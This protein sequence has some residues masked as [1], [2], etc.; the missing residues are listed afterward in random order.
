VYD[1]A[2]EDKICACRHELKCIGEDVSERLKIIPPQVTVIREIRKKYVCEHCEGLE[3]EDEKGV[4]TAQG[5][6][7]LIPGSMADESFL[8]WSISEK[9]EFALP[10]YRQATSANRSINS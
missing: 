10:F 4:V 8:A 1:L 6:K 7:H 3:R 2:E 9:F 5:P